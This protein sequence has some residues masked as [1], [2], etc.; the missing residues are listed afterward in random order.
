LA[1][2]CRA[3]PLLFDLIKTATG[4]GITVLEPA[5]NKESQRKHVGGSNLDAFTD[6]SGSSYSTAR[7]QRLSSGAIM[8][9]AALVPHAR[10]VFQHGSRVDLYA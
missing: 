2:S 8:V 9:A 5:G 6:A 3:D 10:L 1:G 4:L 7:T